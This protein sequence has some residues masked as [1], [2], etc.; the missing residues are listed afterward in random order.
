[1]KCILCLFSFQLV[2]MPQGDA[3]ATNSAHFRITVPVELQIPLPTRGE[4]NKVVSQ[5]EVIHRSGNRSKI[6][7]RGLKSAPGAKEDLVSNVTLFEVPTGTGKIMPEDIVLKFAAES[8][9]DRAKL[10]KSPHL[11]ASGEVIQIAEFSFGTVVEINTTLAGWRPGNTAV[12]ILSKDQTKAVKID[13]AWHLR[14][15]WNEVVAKW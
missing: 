10:V 3:M 8:G 12:F 4:G 13:P 14:F 9:F 2:F 11:K 15:K 6:V 5:P 7:W 1:M